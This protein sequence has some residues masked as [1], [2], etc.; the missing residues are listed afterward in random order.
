MS[1]DGSPPP[2]R[3]G[4]P[5]RAED[6]GD[7]T[8]CPFCHSVFKTSSAVLA[9]IEQKHVPNV[10]SR[11]A[12]ST[13]N[14][15]VKVPGPKQSSTSKSACEVCHAEFSRPTSL[16][17]HMAAKH[18]ETP[19]PTK[20]KVECPF[21][22]QQR[23]N[24]ADHFKYC[25]SRK[26]MRDVTPKKAAS[27]KQEAATGDSGKRMTNRQLLQEYVAFLTSEQRRCV[28]P[29]TAKGYAR[30][31]ERFI[32][33]E[34][35]LVPGFKMRHWF[36]NSQNF[37]ELK[38]VG[39]YLVGSTSPQK[40]QKI[41]AYLWVIAWLRQRFYDTRQELKG[42]Y[43]K[44]IAHLQVMKAFAKEIMK[45]VKSKMIVE[46][47]PNKKVAKMSTLSKLTKALVECPLRLST[48]RRF[49]NGDFSVDPKAGITRAAEIAHFLGLCWHMYGAGNRFEVTSGMTVDDLHDLKDGPRKCEACGNFTMD[50][51]YH[52]ETECAPGR[53][54]YKN[55][56]WPHTSGLVSHTDVHKTSK[57]AGAVA[58]KVPHLMYNASMNY[59]LH[60]GLDGTDLLFAVDPS[61]PQHPI[62]FHRNLRPILKALCPAEVL[63]HETEV[64]K[65]V[66]S[67]FI[68]QFSFSA[69]ALADD[70]GAIK[71]HGGSIESARRSYL[72]A[73]VIAC[74]RAADVERILGPNRDD[75]S[76][77]LSD[78]NAV[79]RSRGEL[80]EKAKTTGKSK[81]TA[82]NSAR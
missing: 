1:D 22:H 41:S 66:P 31:V 65:P 5:S 67:N 28:N 39:D 42:D 55:Q 57:T 72:S 38:R 70:P 59:T 73:D 35:Q 4:P 10:V 75:D 15:T 49:A 11:Y 3:T 77:T 54:M 18:S 82:K 21:C 27:G 79:G 9:H 40:M 46:R 78:S 44:R 81:C 8:T 26:A 36:T 63:A 32:T 45:K 69:H 14:V 61:D 16:K 13:E 58:T 17:R 19:A 74:Q 34:E 80:P 71:R 30:Q 43:E 33:F 60:F 62:T 47:R 51:E 25:Q 20:S 2:P 7:K 6:D 37:T 68:R 76:P 53:D 23:S 56:L 52:L 12:S 48:L 24:L 50:W 29:K 64:G